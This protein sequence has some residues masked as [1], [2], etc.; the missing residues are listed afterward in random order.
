M[1]FTRLG[2]VLAYLG[3]VGGVAQYALSVY[4][5]LTTPD[6]DANRAASRRYLSA[7]TTGEAINESVTLIL[8]S[9]ALGILCEISRNVRRRD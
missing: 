7:A 1:L 4:L 8:G 9:V 5:A 6:M 2:T 3:L